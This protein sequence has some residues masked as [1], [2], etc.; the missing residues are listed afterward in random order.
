M[1]AGTKKN[2]YGKTK[3][4]LECQVKCQNTP[5]CTW[6]NRNLEGDCWL[7]KSKGIKK[8]YLGGISGPRSCEGGMD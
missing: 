5:G 6:F 3:D 1:H 8:S 4:A 7:K 2:N